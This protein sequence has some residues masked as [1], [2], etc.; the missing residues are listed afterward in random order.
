M[1]SHRGFVITA[2]H[3]EFTA[4]EI[5][6]DILQLKKEMRLET[7]RWPILIRLSKGVYEKLMAAGYIENW[8]KVEIKP[9][10]YFYY[11]V[12]VCGIPV[13]IQE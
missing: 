12:T 10:P 13:S 11:K 5:F 6:K 7:G 9:G 1:E 8:S 3:D 4:E 2:K